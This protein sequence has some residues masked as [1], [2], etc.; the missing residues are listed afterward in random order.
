MNLPMYPEDVAEA[1]AFLAGDGAR[2]ITGHV[3]PVDF[4]AVMAPE[5]PGFHMA[6]PAFLGPRPL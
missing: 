3:L 4:G 1:F 6:T 2:Q 5:V